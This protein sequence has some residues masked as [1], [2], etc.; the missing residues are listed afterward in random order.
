MKRFKTVSA[1]KYKLGKKLDLIKAMFGFKKKKPTS[2][3]EERFQE[4]NI[5]LEDVSHTFP[6]NLYPPGES[7]EKRAFLE[8]FIKLNRGLEKTY[9][10][11]LSL[12]YVGNNT[13]SYE[14][15]HGYTKRFV[16]LKD[17]CQRQQ[18]HIRYGKVNDQWVKLEHDGFYIIEDQEFEDRNE[19]T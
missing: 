9:P 6:P 10:K 16:I 17:M 15:E 12:D 19:R 4:V 3:E 11:K 18:P 5:Q 2:E 14:P 8:W 7:E 1:D 13:W